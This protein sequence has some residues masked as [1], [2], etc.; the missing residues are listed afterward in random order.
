[1]ATKKVK[2]SAVAVTIEEKVAK[3]KETLNAPHNKD[4]KYVKKEDVDVL[5]T[6]I[7]KLESDLAQCHKE[8]GKAALAEN[9][10]AIL[11]GGQ[12]TELGTKRANIEKNADE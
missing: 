10:Y 6:Y 2:L 1:M 11:K 7:E 8:K 9:F 3:I 5:L 12:K 4:A